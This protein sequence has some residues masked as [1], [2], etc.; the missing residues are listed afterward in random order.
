VDDFRNYF[1]QLPVA[2]ED[3]W[4]SVVAGFSTPHLAEHLIPPRLQFVAEYRLG[5][6]I[7]TNSN[8]AQ[9][10]ST[11][12]LHLFLEEFRHSEK[13]YLASEP[14]CVQSWVRRRQALARLTGRREDT[15]FKAHIY[16]DDPIFLVIGAQRTLRA[17]TLWRSITLRFNLLMAIPD[18]RRIGTM[19]KWLGFLPCPMH[20]LIVV[21]RAKLLRALVAV[22]AVLAGQLSVDRYRSLL[23][24]LEHLKF[25]LPSPKLRMR[26]LYRPL[27]AGQ[28]LTLG[29]ATIVLVT[30]RMRDSLT[31]WIAALSST[32]LAPVTYALPRARRVT[33]PGACFFISSD[34]AKTGTRTPAIA[35]YMHGSYWHYRYPAAWLCLPIAVLEFLALAV[36]II[37]FSPLLDQVPKIILETDSLTT[38][39]VLSAHSA[40]SELLV[41]AQALLLATP[42]YTDLVAGVH[43]WRQVVIGHV[44]GP[45]NVAADLLS[46]GHH[47]AFATFCDH[48]GV[49]PQYLPMS[50]DAHAYLTAFVS[51]VSPLL[52]IEAYGRGRAPSSSA[53]DGPLPLP[54]R[55]CSPRP[56]TEPPARPPLGGARSVS[57]FPSA[58]HLSRAA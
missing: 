34:A 21:Q 32:A 11:F 56:T 19:V 49:K 39:L 18:K 40:R 5:F 42:Q 37:I 50:P 58:Y 9:R 33:L 43:A 44:Y 20:G 52:P 57:F 1:S 23:G 27:R 7:T 15:L 16:T 41:E 30:H 26:G 38:S 28:E 8:V 24:F 12:I 17:L 51:A 10:L 4:K 45:A 47:A 22:R 53:Y 14:A 31:T 3:L 29:P 13:A 2:A 35:G 54:R 48:L 46:R 6:G 25:L 55:P 36:S